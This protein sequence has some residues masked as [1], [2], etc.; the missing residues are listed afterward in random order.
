MLGFLQNLLWSSNAQPDAQPEAQSDAQPEAQSD[1]QPS[2]AQPD[3]APSGAPSVAPSGAPSDGPHVLARISEVLESFK[4]NV[5]T[6]LADAQRVVGDRAQ[7]F[8]E[9]ISPFT[10]MAGDQMASVAETAGE[11]ILSGAI[12]TKD[13]INENPWTAAGLVATGVIILGAIVSSSSGI[14]SSSSGEESP[15]MREKRTNKGGPPPHVR[16]YVLPQNGNTSC[17][18]SFQRVPAKVREN[19][20]DRS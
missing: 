14:V 13:S 18:K 16:A 8:S 9:V 3:A 12:A 15:H 1:A 19:Q 2:N 10:T 7:K 6:S 17:M 4:T 20:P 5:M 11:Q